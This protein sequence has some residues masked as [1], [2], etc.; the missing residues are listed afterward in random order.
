MFKVDG[1]EFTKAVV[2]KP[3]RSFQIMDGENAGRLIRIAKMERDVLGTFYNYNLNIDSRFMT[4][5]EY[6]ELYELL[7]AP[8]PSHTIEIP[9]GQ[10]ILVYKAYVTN[11][12]DELI[13][14]RNGVNMWA[15]L[16]INFIAME[17]QRRPAQ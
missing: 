13:G 12:T 5:T 10:T 16:S 14:I 3:K 4:P 15:N 7:S 17:P 8:V 1:I 2:D 6:D 11:G 9:Y